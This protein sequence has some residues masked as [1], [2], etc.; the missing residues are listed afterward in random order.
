MNHEARRHAKQRERKHLRSRLTSL[1]AECNR[2]G[3]GGSERAA[4]AVSDDFMTAGSAAIRKPC[5]AQDEG[6]EA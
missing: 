1:V 4:E 2:M 5:R 6:A 3:L